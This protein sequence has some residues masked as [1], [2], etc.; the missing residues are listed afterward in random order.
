MAAKTITIGDETYT[1]RPRTIIV[2]AELSEG[3]GKLREI[4]EESLILQVDGL[5]ARDEVERVA[6]ADVYDRDAVIAV[7]KRITQLEVE[8]E[9]LAIRRQKA[10]LEMV[11]VLLEE[12]PGLDALAAQVD[13]MKIDDLAG[14]VG[15]VP[16]TESSATSGPTAQQSP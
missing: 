3:R 14:A 6:A 9:A 4:D 10:V 15:L 11:D 7:A 5:N 1:V 8:T 12:H 13:M 16:P 2:D